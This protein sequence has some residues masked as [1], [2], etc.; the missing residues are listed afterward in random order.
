MN[1]QQQVQNSDQRISNRHNWVSPNLS[2]FLKKPRRI[3][4]FKNNIYLLLSVRNG[5]E[6]IYIEH[7]LLP[8]II[9]YISNI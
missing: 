8:L 7:E 2:F 4:S 5:V 1:L 9:H 3:I 6:W